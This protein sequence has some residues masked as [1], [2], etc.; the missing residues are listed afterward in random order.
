MAK[1]RPKAKPT[2]KPAS[3]AAATEPR[4]L[5]KPTYKSFRLSQR[6]KVDK[7]PTNAFKIFGGAVAVLARN[8]K[9]FLLVIV[10]YGVLNALL[11]QGFSAAGNLDKAKETLDQAFTGNWAQLGSGLTVFVYLLGASGN[12]A[13]PTAG[14]YQLILVLVISLAVIWLLRQFYAGHKVRARDGFYQ[15]MSSLVQFLLVLS[16][17]VLQ[18]IPMA[19]GLLLFSAV[20]ANHI[21]ASALEAILWASFT[22]ALVLFSLYMLSSSLFALY[23]VTL[24]GMTPL[25]ALRAARQLVA[26][27]RWS[28]LRKV[29]FLP[30]ALVLIAALI[31][32]PVILFATPLAAW[33]FFVLTMLLLPLTHSYMYSLYRSLL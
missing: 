32:V 17:I 5:K 23:I 26:Y 33:V 6:I 8:W 12:T 22:F 27:R 18:L 9:T 11:V 7:P 30:L 28:T 19:L 15:G 16:V 4:Q 24:P 21:A 10:I 20:N 2:K 31:V 13:S 25:Q 3:K 1:A 14:A 29:L